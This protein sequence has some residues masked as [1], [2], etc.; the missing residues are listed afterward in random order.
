MLL[1]G[2]VPATVSDTETESR[3]LGTLRFW[4]RTG[5]SGKPCP[6]QN[7]QRADIVGIRLK[8]THKDQENLEIYYN[9][10]IV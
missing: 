10:F 2:T 4:R 5:Y 1:A 6:T 8:V 9:I 7:I 3:K